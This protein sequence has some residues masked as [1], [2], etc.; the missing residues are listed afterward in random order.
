MDCTTSKAWET[1]DPKHYGP[2]LVDSRNEGF[3]A[4]K[5]MDWWSPGTTMHGLVE[6]RHWNPQTGGVQG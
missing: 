1:G 3:Q 6:S 2:G 5:S 4:L